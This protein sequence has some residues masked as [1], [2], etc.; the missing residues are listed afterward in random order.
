[1]VLRFYE[2]KQISNIQITSVLNSTQLW[3][4]TQFTNSVLDKR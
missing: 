1:M 4:H 2:D 3:L